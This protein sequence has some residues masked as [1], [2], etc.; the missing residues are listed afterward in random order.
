M[1]DLAEGAAVVVPAHGLGDAQAELLLR[2]DAIDQLARQRQRRGIAAVLAQAGR[3][4]DDVVLHRAI[5][6][7]ARRARLAPIG[8]PQVVEPLEVGFLGRRRHVVALERLDRRLVFTDAEDVHVHAELVEAFLEVV[9]VDVQALEQHDTHRIQRDGVGLGCDEVRGLVVVRAVRIHRLAGGAEHLDGGGQL[10]DLR[11]ARAPHLVELQHRERHARI[12]GA[13]LEREGHV[14]H[15][16]LRRRIAGQLL[17]EALRRVLVARVDQLPGRIDH[18]C[19]VVLHARRRPA[20]QQHP[21]A[22]DHQQHEHDD[23]QPVETDDNGPDQPEQAPEQRLG[24]RHGGFWRINGV[25]NCHFRP[26]PAQ[27]L[28]RSRRE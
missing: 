22:A 9:L 26:R 10:L 12:L 13:L 2:L 25:V 23:D 28:F 21:D 24:L 19:D 15:G 8:Q 11:E 27:I 5:G 4:A 16:G 17:E 18:E 14:A 1:V 6:Q 20:L 3:H 7:V